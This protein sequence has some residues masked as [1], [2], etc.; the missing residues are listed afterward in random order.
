MLLSVYVAL[1]AAGLVG[2][3]GIFFQA[4]ADQARGTMLVISDAATDEAARLST[5]AI[6]VEPEALSAEVLTQATAID[7]AVLFSPDCVCHALGVI[8][9]GSAS[10]EGDRA[11]GARLNSALRYLTKPAAATMIVLVSEDG[12]I[13]VLPR[14]RPRVSR[15]TVVRA[16]CVVPAAYHGR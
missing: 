2:H 1:A 7:G 3:G 6:L 12:M 8:L 5:Q 16:P 14:L 10:D 11:R 15:R 4:A 9:D 13:D